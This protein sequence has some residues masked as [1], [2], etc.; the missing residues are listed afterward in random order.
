MSRETV[1]ET[2]VVGEIVRE[3]GQPEAVVETLVTSDLVTE[4]LGPPGGPGVPGPPGPPG[5]NTAA[6]WISN[7]W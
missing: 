4:N 3:A 2:R 5:P 1:V 7:E 6:F